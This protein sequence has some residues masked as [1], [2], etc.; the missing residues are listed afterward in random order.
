MKTVTVIPAWNEELVIGEVLDGL[1]S[2][3]DEMVIVDDGSD[4]RTALIARTRGA[5]VVRHA[6]NRGLGAALGTGIAAALRR[7]AEI[8]ITFDADGQHLPDD[9]PAVLAPIL[10]GDADIVI[11]TRL[12]DPKGMP[13]IRRL[14]NQ[15]GN[16]VTLVLFGVKVTD[17]QSGFRALSRYAAERIE[18]RTDRMEVSSEILAESR[19]KNLKLV[20]VPIRSRYTAYSMSKGQSLWMGLRTLGRLIIHRMGR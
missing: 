15:I 17:S 3:V 9:I 2:R 13:P 7:N 18:I 12:R 20:E 4:D 16:L 11:G 5:T 1:R 14:A 10:S 19:R 8:I 6:V